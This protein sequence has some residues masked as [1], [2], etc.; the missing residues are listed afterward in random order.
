MNA[1][2]TEQEH[3]HRK[4]ENAQ[5]FYPAHTMVVKCPRNRQTQNNNIQTQ[6][7]RKTP[8]MINTT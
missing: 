3:A 5:T 8:P 6:M 4:D 2:V 1:Q 7:K